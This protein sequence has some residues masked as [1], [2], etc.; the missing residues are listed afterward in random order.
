MINLIDYKDFVRSYLDGKLDGL[1]F[2]HLDDG[3]RSSLAK[4]NYIKTKGIANW[5]VVYVN[6]ELEGHSITFIM[7]H[8]TDLPCIHHFE[9]NK[10]INMLNSICW[11]FQID[12]IQEEY[13]ASKED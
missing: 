5:N 11:P 8:F 7:E 2:I 12:K 6:P 10:S 13:N 3:C 1:Y 4:L 9:N